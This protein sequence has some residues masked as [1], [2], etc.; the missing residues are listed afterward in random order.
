MFEDAT[1]ACNLFS[2]VS[3][4]ASFNFKSAMTERGDVYVSSERT[5]E[6]FAV[7]TGCSKSM[8]LSGRYDLKLVVKFVKM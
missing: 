8:P 7:S 5:E 3:F 4:M 6:S 2:S 1:I